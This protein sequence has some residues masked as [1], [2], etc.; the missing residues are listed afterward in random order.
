LSLNY[1]D[2][3]SRRVD[4]KVGPAIRARHKQTSNETTMDTELARLKGILI[5]GLAFIISACFSFSE[6]KFAI[7]GKTAEAKAT[8]TRDTEGTGRRSRPKRHLEYQYNEADGTGRSGRDSVEIDWPVPEN[9]IY[10]VQ[11][12]PGVA[13]S[14]RLLGHSRIVAV[15]LFLGCLAWLGYSGYKNCGVRPMK[16][17]TVPVAAANEALRRET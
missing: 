17:F 16:R 7:W 1:N 8:R 9:G 11:Y 2:I 12:L 10:S 5:A 6:L 13:D 14:S 3:F 4:V 15:Y